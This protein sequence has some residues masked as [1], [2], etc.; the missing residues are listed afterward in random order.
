MA[1]HQYLSNL[2]PLRGAAAV[3]VYLFHFRN[4]VQFISP[5]STYLL[6][7]G[8]LM[9]DLF[10]I[11]SGFIM[12]HVYRQSFETGLTVKKFKRFFVARFARIYPL[13]LFVLIILILWIA[14]MGFG[15]LGTVMD[16]A[17][18]PTNLLLIHSFGIHK[19]FTWNVPSWSISAEWWAYMVFPFLV[20][21]LYR[22]KKLAAAGLFLFVIIAYLALMFWLPRRDPFDPAAIVPHDLDISFDYG[23]L[24]GLAG[25]ISGML[26]YEIYG[27]GLFRK[28]FQNDLTA[29]LLIGCTLLCLHIGMNDGFYIILF[30]GLVYT[31]ACNNGRLHIICN[32]RLA[33]YLGKISYSIYMTGVFV[34]LPF[35]MGLIKLPGVQYAVKGP[36]TAGFLLGAGYTL[37]FLLVQIGIS[38]LT[39]YGV[40]KPCRKYINAKLGKETMPVYA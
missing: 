35:L 1:T 18:I 2:T 38:T 32:N 9:V 15:P 6:S 4:I 31:F 24:R 28:F 22:W 21:F 33:Q 16:P 19:V 5:S 29:L 12:C 26:V 39:Y 34:V 3:W 11:M 25:F 14:K 10:F 36:P 8:Y 7:K 23:F 20:L 27:S 17:A 13:H 40:E 30:A 37:F